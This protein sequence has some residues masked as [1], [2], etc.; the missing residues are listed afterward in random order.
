MRNPPTMPLV[1]TLVAAQFVVMLD[2]SILNVAL[3]SIATDLGLT[4]VGTAWVLNAY[5]LTFGGLLLISGRAA[6]VFGRRRMFLFGAAVLVAGSLMGGFATTDA[7]LIAARLVQ[8]AGAAML[9]PAAM[10]VILAG[11][12]GRDRV[13]AMSGWGA[14]STVGGAAGVTVGGL[15]TAALG[16]QSVLFVT[17]AVAAAIGVA[18]WAL[19]PAGKEAANGARS[20]RPA[21]AFSPV[22]PSPSCSVCC[23]HRTA[24]SSR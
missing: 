23:R 4:P 6:D 21:R 15:L 10:S 9:S 11:F 3:P 2:S 12:T 13:R 16:W 19:L 1:L 24:D 18:G 22:R 17:G 7:L 14:A 8:G 20:M 5:F